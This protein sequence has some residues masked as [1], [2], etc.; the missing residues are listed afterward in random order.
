[1]IGLKPTPR[2]SRDKKFHSHRIFGVTNNFPDSFNADTT[3]IFPNQNADK[4]PTE[5]TAYAITQIAQNEDGMEYSKDYQFMKT[6]KAMGASPNSQGADGRTAF[7]VGCV[8]LLPKTAEDPKFANSDQTYS[9]TPENWPLELDIV[10]KPYARS[11]YIPISPVPD[12]FDGIRSALLLGQSEHRLVGLATQWSQ[13]F[14][15]D[16]DGYFRMSR[17]ICNYLCSQWGA[18]AA[19]T[20]KLPPKTIEQL[21]E[22]ELSLLQIILDWLI[23]LWGKTKIASGLIPT[24]L[25]WGHMYVADGWEIKNGQVVMLMKPWEGS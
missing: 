8:G 2:D 19:T 12:Y 1:M 21:K 13:D 25:Y 7:K 23:N 9:A 6:L 24:N 16:S 3:H 18:Y 14:R 22:Q 17:D 11:S 10:A 5:C 20:T 4:R 15:T